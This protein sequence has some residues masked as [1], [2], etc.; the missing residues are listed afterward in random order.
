MASLQIHPM[1]RGLL[2]YIFWSLY[3][4]IP[5]LCFWESKKDIPGVFLLEFWQF[6][7]TQNS[8][9]LMVNRSGLYTNRLVC[10]HRTVLHRNRGSVPS[11]F[12]RS[13]V[14]VLY[15]CS[16]ISSS[17]TTFLSSFFTAGSLSGSANMA[18][19]TNVGKGHYHSIQSKTLYDTTTVRQRPISLVLLNET[20]RRVPFHFRH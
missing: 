5:I 7:T 18:S 13:L 10:C 2:L 1:L 20:L 19:P 16:P 17:A 3:K 14:L 8:P 9:W 15:L 12:V 6:I 4:S 11:F